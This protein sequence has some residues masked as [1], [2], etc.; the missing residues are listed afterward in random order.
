MLEQSHLL[1]AGFYK[2]IKSEEQEALLVAP[3]KTF[4]TS[5]EIR[6]Q[7]LCRSCEERFG[8]RENCLLRMGPQLTG[9][10]PLQKLLAKQQVIIQNEGIS[11]VS[12]LSLDPLEIDAIA[13][14]AASVFWRSSVHK[15]I[16]E[17]RPLMRSRLG[18]YEEDFRN[19]LLEAVPFPSS[20]RLMIMVAGSSNG[21]RAMHSPIGWREDRFHMHRFR[22][23]GFQFLMAVGA[24]LPHDMNAACLVNS[25]ERPM[26]LADCNDEIVHGDIQRLFSGSDP[27]KRLKK[28]LDLRK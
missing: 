1:A 7:L 3:D 23:P 26:F 24:E 9:D 18:S 8:R 5:K 17:G 19:Y 6:S 14:F 27:S 21:A 25:Q 16:Y 2:L 10:F 20:A 11:A 15:W 4:H 28:E 22:T 12:A 13:Y